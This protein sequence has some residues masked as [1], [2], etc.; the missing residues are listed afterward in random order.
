MIIWKKSI[1]HKFFIC[2]RKNDLKCAYIRNWMMLPISYR[3]KHVQWQ[4][5]CFAIFS[6]NHDF[7]IIRSSYCHMSRCYNPSIDSILISLRAYKHP[8]SNTECAWIHFCSKFTDSSK[9]VISF[10]NHLSH[11]FFLRINHIFTDRKIV[12]CCSPRRGA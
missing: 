12:A 2:I 3:A 5:F 1:L 4:D 9:C 7:C 6:S 10:Q 11:P 8:S